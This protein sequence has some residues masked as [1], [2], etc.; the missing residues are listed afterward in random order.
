MWLKSI[1]LEGFRNY[2]HCSCGLDSGI[3]VVAGENA[4]GKTNLLE[5]VYYLAGAR[6]FRTRSDKELIRMDSGEASVRGTVVSAIREQE[7]RIDLSRR[8]RKKIFV[9]GVRLKSGSELAGRLCCVLF[10]PD[11]LELIRGQSSA[12]RRFIDLAISQLRPQYAA[13]LAEYHRILEQKS[14]ILKDWHEKPSLLDVLDDYS[15]ALAKQGA[16]LIRYRAAWCRKVAEKAA[17]FHGEISGRDERFSVAYRT[18]STIPEPMGMGNRELFEAILE[19]QETHRQAEL[20][21]GQCLTGPHKDELI[22][23]IE[24]LPA[25]KFASQGQARTAALSLKLAEW[26]LAREDLGESPI[27]LLDDVLSELD[28]QRQDYV[29]NCIGGG[30]VM[31]SCCGSEEL[32]RKTG[33]S[34]IQVNAEF[35]TQTSPFRP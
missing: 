35:R 32:R 1:E 8:E 15:L 24:G 30:Q 3:N 14:R 12:R 18:V 25:G 16:I 27:L 33:G 17:L 9:N 11:D 20:E 34:V 10:S 22:P 26:E 7:I 31:I 13:A 5:A 19:H 2:V 4:Q 21:S 28:M 23:E 6:S 29:L